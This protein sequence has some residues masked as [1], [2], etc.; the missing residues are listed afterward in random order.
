M[1]A[2]GPS[3]TLKMWIIA[4]V[5]VF[6][7]GCVLVAL[8]GLM[9]GHISYTQTDDELSCI[10]GDQCERPG[11]RKYFAETQNTLSNLAYLLFGICALVR[12]GRYGAPMRTRPGAMMFGLSL[13]F[14]AICSGYYHATLNYDNTVAAEGGAL[15]YIVDKTLRCHD[16]E[17]HDSSPQVLDMVGVYVV[18]IALFLCGVESLYKKKIASAECCAKVAG[19][20]FGIVLPALAFIAF[21]V[22]QA[23][24]EQS[25]GGALAGLLFASMLAVPAGLALLRL[26][27]GNKDLNAV[28]MW[29][30]SFLGLVFTAAV[31]YVI[32]PVLHWDS[33]YVFA[34]MT[35]MLAAVVGVNWSFSVNRLPGPEI[36]ILGT[37]FLLGAAPR[38]LDGYLPDNATLVV[39]QKDFC[40]PDGFIQA[41]AVWHVLSAL[42][43]ALTF[44][45][46][47]KSRPIYDGTPGTL[48]FPQSGELSAS[49]AAPLREQSV[50]ALLVKIMLTVA[51]IVFLILVLANHERNAV[52]GFTFAGLLC[53]ATLLLWLWPLFSSQRRPATG[54]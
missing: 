9:A 4:S 21:T 14:L 5:I 46:I 25:V 49:L 38:L 24:S 1:E 40:S 47:E 36:V 39:L 29:L 41:H 42:A 19:I 18:L 27:V 31:A 17:R 22:L 37:V 53:A 12:A 52:A 48:L 15:R 34:A 28:L 6:I 50:A 32:K 16:S 30:L 3:N 45:L 2:D 35:L 44:D 13:C 33:T 54:A 43:L 20:G 8:Q 26:A 10:H 23:A 7:S 11:D 51:A